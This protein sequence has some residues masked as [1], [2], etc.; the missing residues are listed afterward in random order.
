MYSDNKFP[1]KEISTMLHQRGAHVDI[2]SGKSGNRDFIYLERISHRL[3]T[4]AVLTF[5]IAAVFFYIIGKLTG[6]AFGLMQIA[7][8]YLV[9]VGIL[10]FLREIEAEIMNESTGI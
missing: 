9:T 1:A 6:I 8:I 7:M 3:S 2:K 10:G 4:A 5:V